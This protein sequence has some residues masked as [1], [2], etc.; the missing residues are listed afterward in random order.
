MCLLQP[1]GCW[2]A[3]RHLKRWTNK[4]RTRKRPDPFRLQ[5]VP[6]ALL[7]PAIL[8]WIELISDSQAQ[9]EGGGG[10][11]TQVKTVANSK[12]G[13]ERQRRQESGRIESGRWLFNWKQKWNLVSRNIRNT[14][15]KL[16]PIAAASVCLWRGEKHFSEESPEPKKKNQIFIFK[17]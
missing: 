5:W 11:G 17:K 8:N 14:R 6:G 12:F 3:D 1:C 15:T 7:C 9:G 13:H 2:S 16:F 4:W 10:G